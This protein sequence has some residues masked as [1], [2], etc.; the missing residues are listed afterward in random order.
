MEHCGNKIPTKG[1]E[2]LCL[3]Y[4]TRVCSGGVYCVHEGRWTIKWSQVARQ[5]AGRPGG[6]IP[7]IRPKGSPRYLE[8][9]AVELAPALLAKRVRLTTTT[10]HTK[11]D[12]TMGTY[13]YP[14]ESL[15]AD[16]YTLK[17]PQTRNNK[18]IAYTGITQATPMV[19]NARIEIDT[20]DVPYKVN[21]TM[22]T[23]LDSYFKEEREWKNFCDSLDRRLR[24]Y[25]E[26]KAVWMILG[27]LFTLFLLGIIVGIVLRFVLVDDEQL[28]LILTG[29]LFAGAFF[30]FSAYFFLMQALVVK[31]LQNLGRDITSFCN[32]TSDKWEAVEFQFEISGKCSVYWDSDFD[33][34]INVTS[35]D[36]VDATK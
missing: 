8:P 9:R 5:E 22:P 21:R 29:S 12:G 15:T 25:E 13:R 3:R 32:E 30:I 24:P 16:T 18:R 33:A 35:T 26:I 20:E 2:S 10:N 27:I 36:A 1:K 6:G 7:V 34:W 11:N 19:L 17:L 4:S 31:P 14:P 23:F 28:G